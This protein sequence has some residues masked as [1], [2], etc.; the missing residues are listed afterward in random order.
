[1]RSIIVDLPPTTGGRR[2][3]PAESHSAEPAKK[4]AKSTRKKKLPT[5]GASAPVE[6]ISHRAASA[7]TG[8]AHF[9]N[10]AT[11]GVADAEN[12]AIDRQSLSQQLERLYSKHGLGSADVLVSEL[13]MAE[14]GSHQ[15]QF[16]LEIVA[17]ILEKEWLSKEA[18]VRLFQPAILKR[19]LSAYFHSA[20]PELPE[21][22]ERLNKSIF[23]P[24]HRTR[25][26]GV[27]DINSLLA[28][29]PAIRRSLSGWDGH[30][31]KNLV[32]RSCSGDE[33]A[34]QWLKLLA[35]CSDLAAL[36]YLN[37]KLR[38]GCSL[39]ELKK[40][41]VDYSLLLP[42]EINISSMEDFFLGLRM[43]LPSEGPVCPELLKQ[44]SPKWLKRL[45]PSARY[46]SELLNF[47]Q[48]RKESG[49]SYGEILEALNSELKKPDEYTSWA[50][51]VAEKNPVQLSEQTALDQIKTFEDK[52]IDAQTQRT[53]KAIRQECLLL[54]M[55]LKESERPAIIQKYIVMLFERHSSLE[56]VSELLN[57]ENVPAQGGRPWSRS[58]LREMLCSESVQDIKVMPTEEGGVIPQKGMDNPEKISFQSVEQALKVINLEKSAKL[59]QSSIP[60]VEKGVRCLRSFRKGSIIGEY[61]GKLIKR[62]DLTEEQRK[63]YAKVNNTKL[64]NLYP[65]QSVTW[66]DEPKPDFVTKADRFVAWYPF[67][68]VADGVKNNKSF[69]D[70]GL[71]SVGIDGEDEGNLLRE[72]NHSHEP[73]MKMVMVIDPDVIDGIDY[74]ER[75]HL[76][77]GV[78]LQDRLKLVVVATK[79]INHLDPQQRELCF[80]YSDEETIRFEDVGKD[81]VQYP[82]KLLILGD[83]PWQ[84][85]SLCFSKT[86]A[87]ESESWSGS[88]EGDSPLASASISED[89]TVSDEGTRKEVPL[90]NEAMPAPALL[91][92][93]MEF[94]LPDAGVESSTSETL[95]PLC[96]EPDLQKSL[97]IISGKLD[98]SQRYPPYYEWEGRLNL[99]SEL[100]EFKGKKVAELRQLLLD[101]NDQEHSDRIVAFYTWQKMITSGFRHGRFSGVKAEIKKHLNL[102]DKK[103]KQSSSELFAL[104]EKYFGHLMER[105]QLLDMMPNEALKDRAVDPALLQ[106]F[107][108]NFR[109]AGKTIRRLA[110]KFMELAL[111]LPEGHD[112]WSL[113]AIH[114]FVPALRKAYREMT[115]DELLRL[116]ELAVYKDKG[117]GGN[118]ALDHLLDI[119]KSGNDEALRAYLRAKI[120]RN[121]K[122]ASQRIREALAESFPT[123]P[124]SGGKWSVAGM[125]EFMDGHLDESMLDDP[126]KIPSTF[127]NMLSLNGN[128][129]ALKE[130]IRRKAID[131]DMTIFSLHT[132]LN[133][134]PC[135]FPTKDGGKW[136][137]RAI[138]TALTKFFPVDDG[139]WEKLL[140]KDVPSLYRSIRLLTSIEY[141]ELVV[142]AHLG[143]EGAFQA[144]FA[145]CMDLK[146]QPSKMAE[147]LNQTGFLPPRGKKAW[148]Y[149]DVNEYVVIARD[150]IKS[151]GWDKPAAP[152]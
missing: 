143:H 16:L 17:V 40:E 76:K 93:E 36:H 110:M 79:D 151:K 64:S 15:F 121:P 140:T 4:R 128:Q 62:M 74:K 51:W 11:G 90:E 148:T 31:A 120:S 129:L 70:G 141:K 87:S 134:I 103:Q 38:Q 27:W 37:F 100:M 66:K 122:Q 88:E 106:E 65:T 89:D 85:P 13:K 29:S 82:E 147:R 42:P 131:E 39:K 123:H 98:R 117:Q 130:L 139:I 46:E 59:G 14:Y 1:M 25:R 135:P 28:F 18:V 112:Q 21:L 2:K 73:N 152:V 53:R 32:N 45:T 94:S 111:P 127:L 109:A 146:T 75:V 35:C 81:I 9:R 144:F 50:A 125:A 52:Y 7:S 10:P 124:A 20:D 138:A 22:L 68:V 43:Y 48:V 113:E 95:P 132:V 108:L 44:A 26:Q 145:K 24:A 97:D 33:K 71:I 101:T 54:I 19:T 86:T 72:L 118:E 23:K 49:D 34:S 92:E 69:E 115:P 119:A 3:R 30:D 114:A 60:G 105:S 137:Y 107:I 63:Y 126:K 61:Q 77:P 133:Q 80:Q 47:I 149:Q 12:F 91:S 142:R 58:V 5:S 104:I 56:V 55:A 102:P 6:R 83:L 136:S 57:R 78:R 84:T 116:E 99:P 96:C 150:Y 8:K 67:T 41:V